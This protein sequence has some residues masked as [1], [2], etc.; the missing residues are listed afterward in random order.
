MKIIMALR[1]IS[2]NFERALLNLAG[3]LLFIAVLLA[4]PAAILNSV[5]LMGTAIKL[6]LSS[7]ALI[8][9]TGIYWFF[10]LL[11]GHLQA[12]QESEEES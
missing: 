4:F 11:K 9:L 6:A 1:W 8:A 12:L 2:E 7:I 3:I 10:D 5:P